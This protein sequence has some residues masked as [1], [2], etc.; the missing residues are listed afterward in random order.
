MST[1]SAGRALETQVF[2][3]PDHIP[4]KPLN[5]L[6]KGHVAAEPQSIL[7]L[8]SHAEA[9]VT[10]GLKHFINKHPLAAQ[11][12]NFNVA[13]GTPVVLIN[14]VSSASHGGGH[15][16]IDKSPCLTKSCC[17]N[18]ASWVANLNRHM[19]IDEMEALQGIPAGRLSWPSGTTRSKYGAM[20]GNGFTVG[21]IGRVALRLLKT[22]GKLPLPWRDAWAD[23]SHAWDLAA[24]GGGA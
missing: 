6:L 3:W 21:V 7:D 16:T 10:A 20:I 4:P 18:G 24:V 14:T 9:N 5:L 13:A 11:K 17:R 8:P 2:S 15:V 19:L 12:F 1:L 22:I 23:E